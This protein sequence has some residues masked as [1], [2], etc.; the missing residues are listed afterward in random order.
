MLSFVTTC[1]EED[2]VKVKVYV[3]VIEDNHWRRE[4]LIAEGAENIQ[5]HSTSLHI[6][7]E[8]ESTLTEVA[9][10]L[11]SGYRLSSATLMT[12]EDAETV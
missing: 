11:G 5:A 10:Y 6:A 2:M 1:D 3:F 8:K 7:S 9:N 4:A 12:Q